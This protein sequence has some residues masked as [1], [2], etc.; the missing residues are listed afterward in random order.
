MS[1]DRLQSSARP[2]APKPSK[3]SAA[4]H[5][6]TQ[7]IGQTLSTRRHHTLTPATPEWISTQA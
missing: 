1:P 4:S 5:Q 7:M 3:F 2:G 6:L